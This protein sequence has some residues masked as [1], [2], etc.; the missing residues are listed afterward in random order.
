MSSPPAYTQIEK[1]AKIKQLALIL[2]LFLFLI[3]L[4]SAGSTILSISNV[5]IKDNGARILVTAIPQ[6]YDNIEVDMTPSKLNAFLEDNGFTATKTSILKMSYVESSKKFYYT[7]NELDNSLVKSISSM[8]TGNDWLQNCG[9]GMCEDRGVSNTISYYYTDRAFGSIPNCDCVYF[10]NNGY[11]NSFNTGLGTDGFKVLIDL[12]GEQ[13]YI[14]GDEQY[15]QLA[16]GK[17]KISWAGSLLG[18]NNI[19]APNYDV[20]HINSAWYLIDKNAYSNVVSGYNAFKVCMDGLTNHWLDGYTGCLSTYNSVLT[21]NLAN[22]NSQYVSQVS[23][24]ESIT[25]FQQLSFNQG[26]MAVNLKQP[27]FK[28]II[29]IELDASKVGLVRLA[30]QPEI[31]Q[32]ISKQAFLEA[33]TKSVSATIKNIASSEGYFDFKITCNNPDMG[34]HA[35]GL[36]FDAG[37]TKSVNFQ[38]YGGNSKETTNYASCTLKV[39]DRAS[40]NSV[41]C[42]FDFSVDYKSGVGEC[43]LNETKCSE[44]LRYLWKCQGNKWIQYKCDGSCSIVNGIA[45]CKEIGI[46]EPGKEPCESC[47]AFA[48]SYLFGS[49]FPE[50]KC[51]A[52]LIALPP[53][54][55]TTCFLSFIQLGLIP[56]VLILVSLFAFDILGKF[57]GIKNNKPARWILGIVIGIICAVLVYVTFWVGVILFILFGIL[58]MFLGGWLK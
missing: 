23:N 13:G 57:E 26:I 48:K 16:N 27:T 54:T 36:N 17:A 14:T 31:T 18:I 6:G 28:P 22:K 33:G 39:T 53:Q 30:G 47:M 42:S 29:T 15:L 49:L 1:M 58:K 44:D 52:Q 51:E 12:D 45:Q 21:L 50:Q 11:V 38:V 41:S 8:D 5:E 19:G 3:P 43:Q 4:T 34:G 40:Q 32:C 10:T 56:I 35:D 9:V 2:A 55:T 25:G 24:V 20:Y 37:E 7:I 46:I